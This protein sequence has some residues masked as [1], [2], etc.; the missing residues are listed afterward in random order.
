MWLEV[1]LNMP[2]LLRFNQDY[3][4]MPDQGTF[5]TPNGEP[6]D[7]LDLSNLTGEEILRLRNNPHDKKLHKKI[8]STDNVQ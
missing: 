1:P 6:D 5:I 7:I 4:F 2:K 8:Y 3:Y